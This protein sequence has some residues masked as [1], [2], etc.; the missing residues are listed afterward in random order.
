M[1]KEQT[2]RLFDDTPEAPTIDPLAPLAERMR[3]RTLDEF[4]GQE[5]VVGPG[6]LLRRL[7]EENRQLPSLIL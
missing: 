3:P 4:V 1:A 5:H 7:I 6:S 2:G